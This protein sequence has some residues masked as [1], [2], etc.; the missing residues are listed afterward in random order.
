MGDN[1]ISLSDFQQILGNTL[2]DGSAEIAGMVMFAAVMCIIFSVVKKTFVF[3]LIMIPA[4]LVF[5]Y[6]GIMNTE[7]TMILII[8]TVL[9]L[10]MTA[11]KA[12]R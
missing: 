8:I 9:G 11:P 5:Y 1:V 4:T 12:L 3:L 7:L 2:F 6:L 10:A